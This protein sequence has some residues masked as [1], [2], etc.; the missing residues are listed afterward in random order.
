ME[1]N[2]EDIKG[3]VSENSE[4]KDG[5]LDIVKEQG[6]SLF[7]KEDLDEYNKN[8]EQKGIQAGI[9]D[10][11]STFAQDVEKILTE[12]AGWEKSDNEKWTNALTRVIRESREQVASL[13]EKLDGS[14]TDNDRIKS[15]EKMNAEMKELHQKE[16]A[17]KNQENI[18]FRKITEL[19]N[20]YKDLTIKDLG[21]FKEP[22]SVFREAKMKELISKCDFK[23]GKLVFL[24]EDGNIELNTSNLSR[25][26]TPKEK[27]EELF[28]NYLDK[29]EKKG[30][31]IDPVKKAEESKKK[32]F[33]DLDGIVTSKAPSDPD[34]LHKILVEH[35]NKKG[36]TNGHPEFIKA[37]IAYKKQ[38][39]GIG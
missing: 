19:S 34:Q 38:L 29:G 22:F 7:T 2:L 39:F 33:T 11:T 26:Y 10:R 1:F 16:L 30:T 21:D 14:K 5:L 36:I 3:A 9:N 6:Y 20:S 18:N 15:L 4:L 12:E 25:P 17:A 24:D 31:G 13:S 8:I 32:A 35:F 27:L 28:D 37:S 23:D